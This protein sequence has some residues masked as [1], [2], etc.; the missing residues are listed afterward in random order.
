METVNRNNQRRKIMTKSLSKRCENCKHYAINHFTNEPYCSSEDKT[1]PCPKPAETER[2]SPQ[3]EP[4]TDLRLKDFVI[5]PLETNPAC[6]HLGGI[7]NCPSCKYSQNCCK[8]NIC[9]SCHKVAGSCG[10]LEHKISPHY[11]AVPYLTIARLAKK[12]QG[13]M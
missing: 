8:A 7:V 12:E 1:Q 10:Y 6:W 9:F 13:A 5:C 4:E 11:T 2:E 3:S